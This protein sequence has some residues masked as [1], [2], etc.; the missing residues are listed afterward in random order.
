[1]RKKELAELKR[2]HEM[3]TNIKQTTKIKYLKASSLYSLFN[4]FIFYSTDLLKKK[5]NT[6]S[7]VFPHINLQITPFAKSQ[8]K[9][10]FKRTPL[11]FFYKSILNF[12]P[13]KLVFL[14][15]LKMFLNNKSKNITKQNPKLNN[16]TSF[17]FYT[18]GLVASP[19]FTRQLILKLIGRDQSIKINLQSTYKVFVKKNKLHS[20]LKQKK[21]LLDVK[22][23]YS[24]FFFILKKKQLTK[25]LP[26]A[27]L[28]ASGLP[29]VYFKQ[30]TLNIGKL[31]KLTYLKK[32]QIKKILRRLKRAKLIYKSKFVKY[33]RKKVT[34]FSRKF[35]R[36]GKKT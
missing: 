5:K 11:S 16:F 24:A 31:F 28:R 12:K 9:V 29:N 20:Y 23:L 4:K 6:T 15:R 10:M 27:F 33:R 26:N 8:K 32:K 22:K 25:K 30:K 2:I 21:N 3:Q 17:G 7:S 34:L 14:K 19:F 18:S 35:I 1:M 36:F 13:F